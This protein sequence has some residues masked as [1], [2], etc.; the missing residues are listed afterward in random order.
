MSEYPEHDKVKALEVVSQNAG[1]FLDWLIEEKE[2]YLCE[3]RD[4]KQADPGNNVEFEPSGFFPDHRSINS[5]LYEFFDIDSKKLEAEKN[6]I[7]EEFR[8][9]H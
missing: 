4:C 3:W 2:F 7:L 6:K 9:Y 8:K 5:L 1:E